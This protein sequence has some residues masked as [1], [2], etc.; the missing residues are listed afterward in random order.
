MKSTSID[1]RKRQTLKILSGAAVVAS[2][3]ATV[4]AAQA[5]AP[6]GVLGGIADHGNNDI[7][8]GDVNAELCFSITVG[9]Q[10]VL[11]M[12]NNTDQLQIVRHVH[13]GIIHAGSLKFDINSAFERSAY[14]ISAGHTRSVV[15]QPVDQLAG[16]V[17]FPRKKFR[18]KPQRIVSVTGNDERGL[19][20]NST[21]SFYA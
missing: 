7:Q 14:A 20:V 4:L 19:L 8:F 1:H 11:R 18:N 6:G 12:T 21:R 17:S 16:E 10:A 13:P 15:L 9:E 2:V 3:P 5:G